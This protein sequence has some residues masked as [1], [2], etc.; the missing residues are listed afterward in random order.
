MD[1]SGYQM[2]ECTLIIEFHSVTGL[3]THDIPATIKIPEIW[4]PDRDFSTI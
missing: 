2:V 4:L 1:S 3:V